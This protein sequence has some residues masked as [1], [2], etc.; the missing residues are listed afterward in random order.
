M[1]I[2][3][4]AA[5]VEPRLGKLPVEE[6]I[7]SLYDQV[8]EFVIYD[9]SKHDQIDL[10]KYAKVKKHVK[11]L[12]N[13]FDSPFGSMFTAAFNLVDSDTALFL[14]YDEI[15]SFKSASLKDIVKRYPLDQFSGV[16]FKLR[17]YYCSRN[18]VFDAC[19]SKGPHI[20]KT[21][22]HP[23]HDMPKSYWQGVNQIRRITNSPDTIDGVRLCNPDLTMFMGHWPY[24]SEDEVIIHHTS[25][26]DPI[27]K[28]VRSFLQYNHTSCLDILNF[29]SYDMRVD[30]SII[31]EIY[32]IGKESI[33]SGEIDLYT[34][35]VPIEYE[36]NEL[37]ERY[38]ERTN[39]L[40]FDP[41]NVKDFKRYRKD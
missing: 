2:T 31:E 16:A 37:L 41:T 20:F 10:S 21:A 19:Q 36:K 28:M 15:F 11:G 30:P 8:D 14:D 38:I 29:Y 18:Y 1:Y 13:P 32:R 40:E 33:L 25:H 39:I 22:H 17:N 23:V 5:L 4:Y 6:C 27:S 24:V 12:W 26:L 9:C 7:E 3:A 35:P 34:E